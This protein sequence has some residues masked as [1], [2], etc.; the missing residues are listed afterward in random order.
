MKEVLKIFFGG[1]FAVL[2][3]I[4]IA[5]PVEKAIERWKRT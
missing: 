5:G 3:A 4:V 1:L 2:L